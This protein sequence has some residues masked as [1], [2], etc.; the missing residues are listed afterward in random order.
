MTF[1]LKLRIEFI[2]II[3]YQGWQNV[4]TGAISG[5]DRDQTS[6]FDCLCL[7]IIFINEL[8]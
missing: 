1:V 4:G 6:I 2:E 8:S 7:L 5:V 3:P